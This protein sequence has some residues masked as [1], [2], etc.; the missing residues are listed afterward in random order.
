MVV[1]GGHHDPICVH[2]FIDNVSMEMELDT[3]SAVSIMSEDIF[4]LHFP[5]KVLE[6]SSACL[7]TYSGELLT[8]QGIAYGKVSYKN[9]NVVLPIHNYCF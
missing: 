7:N 1:S 2:V 3:G 4:R 9:Q 5:H 8:V 6:E